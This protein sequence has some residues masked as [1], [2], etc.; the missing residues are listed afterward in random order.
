MRVAVFGATGPIGRRVTR[1]LIEGDAEV[2][3]VSRSPANL[4]RDFAALPVERYAA[5][6]EDVDASI[7]AARGR[8]LVIHAVGLPAEIFERHLP[9]AGNAVAGCREAGARPFLVTSY[10]SYGPGDEEPMSE[11]RARVG[12]SE[13]AAIREAQERIFLEAG[14][15]VARLPDFYG[16]ERGVSLLNDALDSVRRGETAT[17]PGD[18]DMPRDFAWYEDAGRL[19]VDL[20][21][22]E[23]AYGEAWNVPGSGSES[24]RAILERAARIADTRPRIRR[25]PMWMARVVA[26]FRKDI[27]D[28]LDVMP[29]YYAPVVLDT[30]KIENLL[31]P[32]GTTRYE[33][34]IPATLEWLGR[35]ER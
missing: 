17:W 4:E 26:L 1:E 23:E 33:E 28:F 13:M 2:R 29:L 16:R 27:R 35:E 34:A 8:D 31:G 7:E 3:V 21:L 18:P 5:D 14:G 11:S 15:A 9:I 32:T 22:R 20:A 25:I 12:E 30:A 24:P 19:V 10:W 6:L